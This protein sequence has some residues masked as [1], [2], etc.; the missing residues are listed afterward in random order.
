MRSVADDV[1]LE[2]ARAVARL[3]LEERI[4]LALELGDDDVALY[5]AAHGTSD[6]DARAAFR[7]ARAVG[8]LPSRSNDSDRS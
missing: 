3:S 8:R 5:R 6:A 4:A 1:R 2:A 7:R